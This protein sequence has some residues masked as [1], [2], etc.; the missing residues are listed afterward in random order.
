MGPIEILWGAIV[1][2]FVIIA[3]A[4]GY[5]KELGATVI[6]L[7]GLLVV[8]LLNSRLHLDERLP[9]L[10]QTYIF[11]K[12]DQEVLI[13][14]FSMLLYQGIF[15]GITYA[16]YAGRVLEWEGA[17]AG[18]RLK[19]M[20]SLLIGVI[21]GWLVAGTL[22]YYMDSYEYPLPEQIIKLPLTPLAQE[23]VKFLPPAV[24][25]TNALVIII[26]ILLV[27]RVRK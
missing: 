20:L 25:T 2:M 16:G 26:A 27:L 6:M 22:W 24:L 23:L 15:L 5:D 18:G 4:R 9:K 17:T 21:N 10:L 13:R 8:G 7:A 12:P 11:R 1:L 19:K 3:V 14:L